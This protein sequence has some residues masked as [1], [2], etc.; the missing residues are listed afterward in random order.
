MEV[1]LKGIYDPF[2]YVAPVLGVNREYITHK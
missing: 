2:M 1:H